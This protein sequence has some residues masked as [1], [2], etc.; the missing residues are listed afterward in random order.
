MVIIFLNFG[1]YTACTRELSPLLSNFLQRFSKSD[2]SI[3]Y[4]CTY[5]E[6]KTYIFYASF[7]I[8]STSSGVR[9]WL[10][11][12]FPFNIIIITHLFLSKKYDKKTK[13][14][15]LILIIMAYLRGREMLESRKKQINRINT[16]FKNNLQAEKKSAF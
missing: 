1:R 2:S 12:D 5:E 15:H 4:T 16:K 8:S 7:F 10:L 11:I 14:I 3:V 9:F 13:K 6:F